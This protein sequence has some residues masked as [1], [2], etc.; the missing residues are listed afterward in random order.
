MDIE[1]GV[2]GVDGARGQK[3]GRPVFVE[4]TWRFKKMLFGI[5]LVP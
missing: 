4:E 2:A 5:S 1:G 3:G